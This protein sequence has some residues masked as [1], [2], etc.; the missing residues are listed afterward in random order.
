MLGDA[1]TPSMHISPKLKILYLCNLAV[2]NSV[3]AMVHSN[4]WWQL[5]AHNKE[6]H[7]NV[8]FHNV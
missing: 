6:N 1:P 2:S 8:K 3:C 7:C 4:Q 5:R